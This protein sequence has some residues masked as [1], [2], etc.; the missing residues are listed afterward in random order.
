MIQGIMAQELEAIKERLKTF[1]LGEYEIDAYM[2]LL[3][4][5]GGDVKEIST[6]SKV[7][8]TRLYDV[9][10]TL[11]VKG[12]VRGVGTRPKIYYPYDPGVVIEREWK[13]L[14]DIK[15]ALIHDLRALAMGH[16]EYVMTY[17]DKDTV[18]VAVMGMIE[19][20]D[21]YVC[22]DLVPFDELF[23]NEMDK[24]L[25]MALERGVDL[26][27]L[28]HPEGTSSAN[29]AIARARTYAPTLHAWEGDIPLILNEGGVGFYR[30]NSQGCVWFE[31]FRD[32]HLSAL[33]YRGLT[34]SV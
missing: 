24:A 16:E 9:L 28:Y 13:R 23:S 22:L 11:E 18:R 7:P 32:R 12:W 15:S 30:S 25:S 29:Q 6:V 26:T 21:R 20:A 27:F 5:G 4:L 19:R 31:V 33:I 34:R 14:L 1:G 17:V 10:N 8:R 2:S 3:R